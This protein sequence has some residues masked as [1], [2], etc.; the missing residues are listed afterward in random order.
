[1]KQIAIVSRS[2]IFCLTF[3]AKDSEREPYVVSS[4][5]FK[6]TERETFS[7]KLERKEP[8]KL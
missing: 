4:T 5:T 6:R 2:E 8:I 3:A 1:M 7:E